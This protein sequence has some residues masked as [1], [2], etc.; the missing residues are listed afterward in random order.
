MVLTRSALTRRGMA[1]LLSVGLAVACA[2]RPAA[3]AA[4]TVHKDPNCGC[5]AGW[6][7]H[8]TR[9]GFSAT[10]VNQPDLTAI[11]ARHGVPDAVLS[12]HTAVIDGY[13]VEGH[14]P[15]EDIKRLIRLKPPA[16]GLAVPGMPVGSP[17]METPDGRREPYEVLLIMRDGSSSAF[18]HHS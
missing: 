14:V 15:A 17:G 8:L 10:V 11:R 9:A 13:F 16:L 3:A 2:P 12:C 7:D 4:L 6:V 18:A 1:G 5:C